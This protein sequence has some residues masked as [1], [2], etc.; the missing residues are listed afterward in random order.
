MNRGRIAFIDLLRGWALLVM[1][2]THVVNSMMIKELREETWFLGLNF[3]NGLVAPSF[4]FVTGFVFVFAGRRKLEDY[5]L[6]GSALWKQLA[7]LLL[8]WVIGYALHLPFFSFKKIVAE[9][10]S[11]HWSKFFQIDIL[12]CIAVGW[13][14]LLIILMAAKTSNAARKIFLA[15]GLVFVFS[16]PF[17]WASEFLQNLPPFLSAYFGPQSHSLFPLFPWVGFMLFGAASADYFTAS[18]ESDAH[19]LLVK[20]VAWLGPGLIALCAALAFLLP[21]RMMTDDWRINPLFFFIRLGCVLVLGWFCYRWTERRA[22]T[23]SIVLDVSRAS[24]L[25][26]TAHLLIIY[27]NYFDGKSIAEIVQHRFGIVESMLA[28][29]SLAALMVAFAKGWTWMKQYSR[30]GSLYVSYAVA[31]MTI[32]LFFVREN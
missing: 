13:I 30:T 24:L 11:Q 9:A 20:K 23:Q 6:F 16:T 26:Y 2:E 4:L 10:T 8:V 25:V 32:V 5:R 22:A 31:V 1:I 14:L 17:V 3:V 7:R 18:S 19:V 28:A 21:D 29:L 27:G 15:V 12:Q